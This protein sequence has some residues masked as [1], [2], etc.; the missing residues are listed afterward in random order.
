MKIIP[1][2]T[3]LLKGLPASL[4]SEPQKNAK[5]EMCA[6][7]RFFDVS[8]KRKLSHLNAQILAFSKP[9]FP[10]LYIIGIICLEVLDISI[11]I[12]PP[13]TPCPLI[14]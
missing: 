3:N 12:E 2:Y 8:V 4:F 10:L 1:F 5:K 11:Y 6:K 13:V 14:H 7:C 9:L